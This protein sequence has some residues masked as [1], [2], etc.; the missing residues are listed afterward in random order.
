MGAQ[1]L[2]HPEG[3]T[4]EG[5]TPCRQIWGDDDVYG[6]SVVQSMEHVTEPGRAWAVVR[7]YMPQSR[8]VQAMKCGLVCAPMSTIKQS[9]SVVMSDQV[10][11]L[12]VNSSRWNGG[13]E[14]PPHTHP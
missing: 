8:R 2:S 4:L 9:L 10:E 6:Y 14:I 7:Q 5:G 11:T 1:L 3:V 13:W 12:W